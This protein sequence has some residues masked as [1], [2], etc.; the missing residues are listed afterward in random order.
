[1]LVALPACHDDPA[2]L[3][4]RLQPDPARQSEGEVARNLARVRVVVDLSVPGQEI[5][6]LPSG[7]GDGE[8]QY[9]DL[10][11]DG[12]REPVFDLSW[13]TADRLPL[14]QITSQRNAGLPIL[15]R[16]E[17]YDADGALVAIGGVAAAVIGGAEETAVPFN[18]LPN[19]LPPRVV[20]TQPEG[21]QVL[22]SL[23][24]FAVTFSRK[25]RLDTVSPTTVYLGCTANDGTRTE[26]H[27]TALF[28]TEE[29]FE[30]PSLTRHRARGV[31]ASNGSVEATCAITVLATVLADDGTPF[32]QDATR[33]GADGFTGEGFT[34]QA[35]NSYVTNGCSLPVNDPGYVD[36]QDAGLVCDPDTGLC[37]TAGGCGGCAPGSLCDPAADLC[38]EDC[39]TFGACLD[40]A[41]TCLGSG[42]CG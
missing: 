13:P 29:T 34:I 28:V 7:S 31:F 23:G 36:C 4:V 19:R 14:L 41:A 38:V 1:V 3:W 26:W 8:L 30:N 6:G 39:R 27:P 21:G 22:P 12:A 25:L 24:D 9:L 5:S 16:V 33:P 20:A 17:G 35:P 15:L 18:L 40:P 10:D 11:G 37:V 42:L 2:G 32:D